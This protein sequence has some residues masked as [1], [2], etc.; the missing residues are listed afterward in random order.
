[1]HINELLFNKRS[2]FLGAFL[3]L[4]IAAV[5]AIAITPAA[6]ADTKANAQTVTTESAKTINGVPHVTGKWIKGSKGWWFKYPDGTWATGFIQPNSDSRTY[7]LDSKGWMKTGWFKVGRK[8]YYAKS[9]GALVY[10]WKKWKGSWYYLDSTSG[11]MK[12][13]WVQPDGK[14]WYFLNSSGAM[15]TGWL[16]VGGKWYYADGSGAIATGWK[17]VG[18][19]WYYFY[20][21]SCAMAANTVIEGYYLDPSGAMID[22]SL[23]NKVAAT[24]TA[25]KTNQIVLVVGHQL[26]LWQK[27]SD[28]T[29]VNYMDVYCGYGTNGMRSANSRREGDKTTPIGSFSIPY[30]FGNAKNPGTGGMSYYRTTRNTYWSAERRTYNTWVESPTPIYGEHLSSIYQYKYAAVIGFNM[31]PTVYGRG[32]ALFIH[33]K[34]TNTWNTAGCVSLSEASMKRL[35]GLLKNDAY[36][37]IVPSKGSVTSY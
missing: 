5:L 11:A 24:A 16:K 26:T 20:P 28:G 17:K 34:S 12:T 25:K 6:Y 33:C 32:S 35:L 3:A 15:Q 27:Q 14:T 22:Q 7:Y 36:I 13:G 19:T 1:M 37:I 21:I 8:W 4:V 29:W 23:R 9:S 18:K 31:N 10:G 2:V 30:A